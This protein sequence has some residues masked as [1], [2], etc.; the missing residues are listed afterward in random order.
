MIDGKEVRGTLSFTSAKESFGV[1]FVT[2]IRHEL[3]FSR[4]GDEII[5]FVMLLG[6]ELKTGKFVFLADSV[7]DVKMVFVPQNEFLILH[8]LM[9]WYV[10]PMI[11]SIPVK[12]HIDKN[13]VNLFIE[14]NGVRRQGR[15]AILVNSDTID[16]RSAS[17]KDTVILF[18]PDEIKPPEFAHIVL[19]E[20]NRAELSQDAQ[21]ELSYIGEFLKIYPEMKVE[22]AGHCDSTGSEKRNQELSR[23]RVNAVKRYLINLGID[24]TRII[25]EWFSSHK[26]IL[27]NTK[28]EWR[29]VNRRTEIKTYGAPF[30]Y[31]FFFGGR[32]PKLDKLACAKL[33]RIARILVTRRTAN[34]VVISYCDELEKSFGNL[35]K[36]RVEIIKKYLLQK[37]VDPRRIMVKSINYKLVPSIGSLRDINRAVEIFIQF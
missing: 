3:K 13:I 17:Y 32:E 25:T 23:A 27:P 22:L 15:L 8:E 29:E 2:R 5:P 20:V 36:K 11:D 28:P 26:P 6:G 37:G 14:L 16:L 34:A 4:K 7:Y 1:N 24:S 30:G 9:R 33:D 31:L 12:S 35:P 21:R 10:T 18:V 19:F